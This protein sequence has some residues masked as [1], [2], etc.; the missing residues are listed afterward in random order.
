LE[1]L[2]D[3]IEINGSP[4]RAD[5]LQAGRVQHYDFAGS[6]PLQLKTVF[7]RTGDGKIHLTP[8]ALGNEPY[9]YLP[10]DSRTYPLAFLSPASSKS[11]NSTLGEWSFRTLELTI[12]PQDAAA[13]TVQDGDRVRVFN[14]IG[15]VLCVA[16]VSDRV[17]EGVV[18]MPKG[19]WMN[20]SENGRTATALCPSHVS[21]VGGGACYNDA[22]VEVELAR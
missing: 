3:A 6:S 8:A 7:P 18:F 11:I 19:A 4:A 15:E 5:I 10:L 16:R 9:R 13:R 2:I 1:R 14:S 20:V 12:H 21:E 22:R 17:R